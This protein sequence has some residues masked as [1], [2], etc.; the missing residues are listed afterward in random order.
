M[1]VK[2]KKVLY[3]RQ[4]VPDN[5]VDGTFLSDLRKNVNL[6]KYSLWEAFIGVSSV[7][8]E[9]SCT[10]LFI[11]TFIFLESET[12]S[13]LSIVGGIDTL[14]CL[15]FVIHQVTC[16]VDNRWTLNDLKLLENLKSCVI[17]LAFGYIF[18]PILKDLTKTISTDT[19][20]AMVTLMMLTHVLFQDYGAEAAVV[21]SS[22]SLNSA[23]FSAVCLSSRLPTVLHT[24]ALM[25]L[26]V[27]IFVL[28]PLLRKTFQKNVRGMLII[29]SVYIVTVLFTLYYL[30]FPYMVLFAVLCIFCN[31]LF[32]VIFVYFQKYKEN[33]FGPWDEAVVKQQKLS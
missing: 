17:F 28:I 11:V 21:S 26:A 16:L 10:V 2:W 18:S 1:A 29:T 12:Y 9:V 15:T 32:P 19:T 23:L 27:K 7:T 24:F 20:Y 3:D 14:I 4:G 6:Y 25:M 22:L 8:H 30:S 5:Y 33:I 13:I 31:I